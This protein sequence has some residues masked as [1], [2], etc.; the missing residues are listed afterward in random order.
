MD[1]HLSNALRVGTEDSEFDTR[2][3]TADRIG[4]ERLE[5]IQRESGA[6][7]GESVPVSDRNAEIVKEL[8]CRRLHERTAR[9]QRKKLSTEGF[10]HL[11]KQTAAQVYV[12]AAAG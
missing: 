11:S 8:Q 3:R 10:V 6:S 1:G 2:Q 5:V 9:E 12:G 7:L 4:A